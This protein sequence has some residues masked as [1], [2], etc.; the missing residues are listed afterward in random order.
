M[1]TDIIN[2]DDGST[3]GTQHLGTVTTRHGVTST[4]LRIK[5]V[6]VGAAG[7]V[8][9]FSYEANVE[10]TGIADKYDTRL[11]NV[12]NIFN[13]IEGAGTATTGTFY[14][15]GLWGLYRNTLDNSLVIA[16][17]QTGTI[18]TVALS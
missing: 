6:A 5:D 7:H 12:S 16:V 10:I 2:I 4:P 13:V 11:D 18:E 14:A 17:N 15:D 8:G 3:T 1:A 9:S